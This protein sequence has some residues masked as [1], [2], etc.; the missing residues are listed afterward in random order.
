MAVNFDIIM[1]T[2]KVLDARKLSPRNPA[3]LGGSALN[4][5]TPKKMV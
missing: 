2:S 3:A 4:H 5:P 1:G